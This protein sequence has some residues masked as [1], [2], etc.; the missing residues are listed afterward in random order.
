[1]NFKCQ[2]CVQQ[3][4]ISLKRKL[5]TFLL[6]EHLFILH[7]TYQMGPEIR[8]NLQNIYWHSAEVVDANFSFLDSRSRKIRTFNNFSGSKCIGYL[9]NAQETSSP[10]LN[11]CFHFRVECTFHIVPL[12]ECLAQGDFKGILHTS[13]G[14]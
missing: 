8:R 10:I 7:C 11:Q 3:K 4:V 12:K 14:Y 1:M 9:L 2:I 5:K 6:S 13:S